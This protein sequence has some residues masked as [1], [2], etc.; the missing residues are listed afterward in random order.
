MDNRTRPALAGPRGQNNAAP[1]HVYNPPGS[2]RPSDSETLSIE[3][4]QTLST[5]AEKSHR[6]GGLLSGL[7]A[8]TRDLEVLSQTG[9]VWASASQ[10]LCASPGGTRRLNALTKDVAATHLPEALRAE[11]VTG[12]WRRVRGSTRWHSPPRCSS[13]G[14]G[15]AGPG[16]LVGQAGSCQSQRQA[17][18]LDAGRQRAPATSARAPGAQ[19]QCAPTGRRLG[20]RPSKE[21]QAYLV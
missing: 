1:A 15:P 10:H 6:A 5:Y 21:S 16:L 11:N 17:T 4:T 13:S 14:T 2:H 8:M 9:R 19:S 18:S 3:Q 20:F 12:K 7:S